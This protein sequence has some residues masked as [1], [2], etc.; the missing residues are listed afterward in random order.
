NKSLPIQPDV[1]DLDRKDYEYYQPPA[2]YLAMS[3]FYT[4]GNLIKFDELSNIFMIRSISVILWILT[5][6][7]TWLIIKR[8]R[9]E[10]N[11]SEIFLMAFVGLLPSYMFIS[12]MIN[13]DNLITCLAG[14]IFLLAIQVKDKIS[15]KDAI[16]MAS[17]AAMSFLTKY[18]GVL[19]LV[20]LVVFI[21]SKVEWKEIKFTGIAPIIIAA[22]IVVLMLAPMLIRNRELYGSFIPLSVGAHFPNWDSIT[23][24]IYRAFK[25]FLNTFWGVAGRTNDIKFIPAIIVGNI[26]ALI[27]LYGI[28]KGLFSKDSYAGRF[29]NNNISFSIASFISVMIGMM[30]LIYYGAKYGHAQGRF[31]FPLII[32]IGIWMAVGFKNV[33]GERVENTK[34]ILNTVGLFLLSATSF[35]GYVLSKFIA[36]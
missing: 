15:I 25:N 23:Y 26:I 2:Y 11:F 19:L 24:G 22:F 14:I 12:T 18:T 30:I 21:I 5:F 28:I 31:I 16:L 3:M 1:F 7:A 32:P 8:L 9:L 20:F 35:T 10:S 6:A 27:A 13:N 29:C 36:S 34:F 17:F 4:F 33:I